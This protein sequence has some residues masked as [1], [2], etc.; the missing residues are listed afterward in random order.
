MNISL[1]LLMHLLP[2]TLVSLQLKKKITSNCNITAKLVHVVSSLMSMLAMFH[3]H[4]TVND[5]VFM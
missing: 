3:T 4:L 2:F 5:V 1:Y